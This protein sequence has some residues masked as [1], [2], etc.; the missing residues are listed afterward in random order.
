MR[1]A[2]KNIYG[3]DQVELGIFKK[4]P[5]PTFY[6]PP[7]KDRKNLKVGSMAKLIFSESE[8]MWVK[9]TKIVGLGNYEGTLTNNPIFLDLNF[10]QK[11]KFKWYHIIDIEK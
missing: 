10:G 6:L 5:T 11:L 2:K 1:E 4:A 7:D 9:V 8:R 3:E